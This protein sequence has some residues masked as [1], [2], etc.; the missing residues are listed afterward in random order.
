MGFWGDLKNNLN[1]RK[2]DNL[3]LRDNDRFKTKRGKTKKKY[4]IKEM[5]IRKIK[6]GIGKAS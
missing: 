4:N 2:D 1:I 6:V 3:Q 5:R